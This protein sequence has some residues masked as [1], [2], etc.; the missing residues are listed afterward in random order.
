MYLPPPPK[1]HFDDAT[2]TLVWGPATNLHAQSRP[3]PKTCNVDRYNVL[4]GTWE[5]L[6]AV[7]QDNCFSD[8]SGV[9]TVNDDGTSTIYLFGGY[10][11][12]YAGR[13]TVVTVEISAD[14]ELSFSTTTPMPIVSSRS[15]M[16][17]KKKK[18]TC[19]T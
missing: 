5:E 6:E 11:E 9:A 12:G 4:T 13:T 14:D 3:P 18:K 2:G 10:D 16:F 1:L 8:H 17:V 7:Q 15:C 19:F